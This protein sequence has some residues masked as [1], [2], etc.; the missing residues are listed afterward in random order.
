MDFKIKYNSSE[1]A[2]C[3]PMVSI[4]GSCLLAIHSVTSKNTSEFF[5][6]QP[7]KNQFGCMETENL[8]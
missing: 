1:L 2:K 4:S 5:L 7:S 6:T 3:S 8:A